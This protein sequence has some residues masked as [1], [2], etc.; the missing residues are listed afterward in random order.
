MA[1]RERTPPEKGPGV[2]VGSLGGVP[3][4]IGWSWLVLAAVI[5]ALV[6]PSIAAQRPD[7]GLLAYGVGILVALGLLL[8]VLVHEGAH[9]VSARAFGLNVRR[10]V[11]DLMGGHTA[12]DGRTTPWSQGV[13]AV[14]GPTANLLLAGIAWPAAL[15]LDSGVPAYLA[16]MLAQVNLLL[17]LFNLL[18]GLP[19]DGGQI[20]MAV[21]WRVTGSQHRAAVVAGWSGRVVAVLVVGGVLLMP[22]LQGR[23][24]G[25]LTVFWGLLIA[26][27]LWRGASQSIVVG[28]TRARISA[29]PLSAVMR[30]VTLVR[31]SEPVASWWAGPN[32]VYVT[33][34]QQGRPVGI[35][36]A[37]V[38]ASVPPAQWSTV[39]A[40]AVAV[41]A[42][43][44]WVREFD[45]APTLTDVLGAMGQSGLEVLLVGH[46]GTVQGIVFGAD[47]VRAV[48]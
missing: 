37:D 29:I 27:F 5:T 15:L 20:L 39:P 32:R 14:S 16:Q 12:F 30:P 17:A 19:L 11:A 42:P 25:L 9:A 24:P 45:E 4:F 13:T 18:P 46:G 21:V 23:S 28:Q 7:L 33:A 40:S 34:D 35:V 43:T 6:G 8:S 26:G 3:V 22:V 2:R 48:E 41:T 38:V 10:V 36:R 47:A 1:S 31:S 44:G